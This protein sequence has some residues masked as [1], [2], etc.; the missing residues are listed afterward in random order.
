[1]GSWSNVFAEVVRLEK[2]RVGRWTLVLWG[3]AGKMAIFLEWAV[4][5]TERLQLNRDLVRLPEKHRRDYTSNNNAAPKT[6]STTKKLITV[7]P[8]TRRRLIRAT[9]RTA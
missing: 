5:S 9:A 2:I 8:I 1:M 3:A 7:N 4:S 6:M